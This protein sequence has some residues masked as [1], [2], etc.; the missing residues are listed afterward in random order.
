MFAFLC[1]PQGPAPRSNDGGGGWRQRAARS[2][3][4][5]R[6][7]GAARQALRF[8]RDWGDGQ[9]AAKQIAEYCHE[10]VLDGETTHPM[11]RRLAGLYTPA[12]PAKGCAH[13]LVKML[14]GCEF[15]SV[16][17]EIP[18][19]PPG[20]LLT[21]MISPFRLMSLIQSSYPENGRQSSDWTKPKIAASGRALGRAAIVAWAD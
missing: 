5:E 8:L 19:G 13:S 18:V 12:A 1:R 14:E 7:R 2:I 21:H 17:Q 20:A 4:T 6:C 10:L 15:A 11:N 3:A 9:L 16:L